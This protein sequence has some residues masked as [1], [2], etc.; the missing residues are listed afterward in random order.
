MQSTSN[1]G[2]KMLHVE[3]ETAAFAAR[4]LTRLLSPSVPHWKKFVMRNIRSCNYS[5]S[6]LVRNWLVRNPALAFWGRRGI[7]IEKITFMRL[8]TAHIK[9]LASAAR[10]I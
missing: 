1:K 7:Y 9:K 8:H 3:S 5:K 6:G 10:P 2:L 4:W